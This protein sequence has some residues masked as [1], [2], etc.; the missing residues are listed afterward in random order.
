MR[1]ANRCD[2]INPLDFMISK[3]LK[4][5]VFFIP[6]NFTPISALHELQLKLMTLQSN[7]TLKAMYLNNPLLQFYRVYVSK[8]EFR[9]LRAHV[10]KWSSVFESTYLCEQFF[11]K[12]NI[13]KSRCSSRLADENLSM[14]LRIATSSVRLNIKR[15]V[16]QKF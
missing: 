13:T 3:L 2:K 12:F 14:L 4:L 9:N 11:S 15:F 7:D 16:K 1:P 8:K 5:D 6:F 10:R